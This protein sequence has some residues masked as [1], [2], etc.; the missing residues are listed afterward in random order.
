ML[1]YFR[2]KRFKSS[3]RSK[4]TKESF[5]LKQTLSHGFP[6]SPTCMAYDS[7]LSLLA[8]GSEKGV[9]KI[10]GRPGV[11]LEISLGEETEVRSIKFVEGRGQLVVLC[12]DNSLSLWE[13]NVQKREN[14]VEK[15][16]IE[17]VKT[18][19]FFH[20]EQREGN[21]KQITT[22]TINSSNQFL[23][24]G[25]QG[26]NIY[27]LS[28]ETFDL[29]NEIIY[30]DVVI[31][32]IPEDSLKKSNP[33]EVEVIVEKPHDPDK[34][35][36]GYNRGLLVLW[37]N[38]NLTTEHFYI[39]NQQLESV[40]WL[41]NGE[42]FIS[43]H[44]DGIYIRWKLSD[45]LKPSQKEEKEYGPYACKPITKIIGLTTI[46]KEE[47]LI[48]GNGLPRYDFND[49]YSVTI[50]KKGA[51][52]GE[53][54]HHVLDF[55]SAVIDFIVINADDKDGKAMYDYPEALLVLTVQEIVAI[56]L[57]SPDWLEYK[58]PYLCTLNSSE[59]TS[60]QY[61]SDIPDDV[62]KKLQSIGSKQNEN[63]Y[64]NREWPIKG[65]VIA[66]KPFTVTN[67]V[68]VTGHDNGTVHFWAA[69]DVTLH[70]LCS[71]ETVKLFN[72]PDDDIIPIDSD[73]VPA[74]ENSKE[75][76]ELWPP[77]R[78]VGS[79]DP[80]VDNVRL[81]I[82][83]VVFSPF[84]STLVVGGGCGQVIV[85]SLTDDNNCTPLV[86][87]SMN[88]I[89]PEENF[90]WKGQAAPKPR[91][92]HVKFIGFTALALIQTNPPSYV[93]ALA[94]HPEWNLL[95]IGT[96]YGF[97][98]Y[99]FLQHTVVVTKSTLNT[100]D[101]AALAEDNAPISR[102]KSFRKSVRYSFRNLKRLRSLRDIKKPEASPAS[103]STPSNTPTKSSDDT[104]KQ[105]Q[106]PAQEVKT[107]AVKPNERR[108]ESRP[109][110]EITGAVVNCL[111]IG[112]AGIDKK[113]SGQAPTLWVGTRAGIVYAFAFKVPGFLPKEGEED[114]RKTEKITF[115]Y[116]REIR[117]AHAAPVIFIHPIDPTGYPLPDPLEVKHGKARAPS[118]AD[119]VLVCT[120][121]QF[122]LFT[123]PQLKHHSKYKLTAGEGIKARHIS[124]SSFTSTIDESVTEQCV[125]CLTNSREV[126]V[127]TTD[128]EQKMKQPLVDAQYKSGISFPRFTPHAEAL[129][130][131]LFC[132]FRR[133]SLSPKRVVEAV[134]L[135]PVPESARPK[136]VVE[137]APKP[138]LASKEAEKENIESKP[139]DKQVKEPVEL[140]KE[141]K[142][143]K[144]IDEL[145]E[146]KIDQT[147]TETVISSQIDK[148][149]EV[150]TDPPVD[151]KITNTEK[152]AVESNDKPI[153]EPI[154]EKND[155]TKDEPIEEPIVEKK[156]ETNE[157]PID[158]KIEE[159]IEEKIDE[160][161]DEKLD[162]K[163]DEKNDEKLDEKI[164]EKIDEKLDEKIDEKID[165][166]ADK[167]TKKKPK[168]KSKKKSKKPADKPV[169]EGGDEPIADPID[170]K[171]DKPVEELTN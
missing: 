169:D 35:L 73:E 59:I 119:K 43:S 44:A 149:I 11:E 46:D 28:L 20:K 90:P 9:I 26:G 13:I 53:K 17:Q 170:K 60:C 30:Q 89:R 84:S 76:E 161:I 34:F 51:E 141:E 18:C 47:F 36:I 110:D 82:Q 146:K 101:T 87:K 16:F 21:L 3:T 32:N 88:I 102:H 107:F 112:L 92:E 145:P 148:A 132:E 71:L 15:S 79:Y 100:K 93:T 57:Q 142:T 86:V 4:L 58:L 128:L 156:D 117:L 83:K 29:T 52:K 50:I 55:P 118:A 91:S 8:I 157:E 81:K 136:K 5:G 22:M 114:L 10:N 111:Y 96:D 39:S 56:D 37:D 63:K 155:E 85:F 164:D 66:E 77:F 38:K 31:Q 126:E 166:G 109:K 113:D 159:K 6:H 40:C 122:I 105:S 124:I 130:L 151:V 131:H 168:K 33:G 115:N 45:N 19:S 25:T 134:C 74:N 72:D 144:K 98:L 64:T 61:F 65:G 129:Y 120:E 24:V 14:G 12:S 153:E 69:G 121:E 42:E 70:H 171:I 54:K 80:F 75:V 127:F 48:F 99:D 139:A 49:K 167:L 125:V 62:Y 116:G 106:S 78:N 94:W 150:K 158:E 143:D 165:M 108:V 133:Y 7:K 163:I 140:P 138:A 68:L 67:D 123:L 103:S 147:V 152:P 154:I 137:V 1:K 41:R 162:E 27:I 2:G 104:S 160:K 135:I 95:A 97:G 23:L